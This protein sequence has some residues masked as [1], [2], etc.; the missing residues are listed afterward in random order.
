MKKAIALLLS[1][2]MICALAGCTKKGEDE[3]KKTKKT[4]ETEATEIETEESVTETEAT[5]EDTE[6]S[7]SESESSS[8]PETK[9]GT[10][11]KDFKL[12]S[13]FAIRNDQKNLDYEIVSS[14]RAYALPTSDG[15]VGKIEK[16]SSMIRFSQAEID[17]HEQLWNSL[18]AES[19]NL[20]IVLNEQYDK[21]RPQ[22]VSSIKDGTYSL[23]TSLYGNIWVYRADTDIFSY[24]MCQEIFSPSI[25][26][27]SLISHTY[28]ASD[29]GE[30][31][32]N[33]IVTDRAGFADFFEKFFSNSKLDEYDIGYA[34]DFAKVL[35]DENEKIEFVL[36]YDA[37]YIINTKLA[38]P[39]FFKIPAMYA[40][41]YLDVSLFGST[42]E[43]YALEA[44]AY[45]SIT[46][47][48]DGDGALDLISVDYDT[49]EYGL[50][51]NA[52]ISINGEVKGTIP[53]EAM[54]DSDNYFYYCFYLMKT[55]SG[56]YAYLST[57]FEGD[58]ETTFIFH[59]ENGQFVYVN[60][61][62][63]TFGYNYMYGIAPYYDPSRFSVTDTNDIM[64]TSSMRTTCSV[65]GN[66]GLPVKTSDFASKTG[67]AISKKE[68]TATKID[69]NG[70]PAGTITIPANTAIS[71]IGVDMEK[72]LGLFTTL[73]EDES[74]NTVFQMKVTLTDNYKIAYGDEQIPQDDLFLGIRYAD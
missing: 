52:K 74:K 15:R 55:D 48:I 49:D 31:F 46:W 65:I 11:L 9:P 16:E 27:S 64:A 14:N 25:D 13:D 23:D 50:M 20:N 69:E 28:R 39:H 24:V 1:I 59:Y 67:I 19:D 72:D 43:Y 21:L 47:D 2:S 8:E 41:D 44:D 36:S 5:S 68:I 54:G 34:K 3:T 56:F 30:Y 18:E 29:G 45:N 42:P 58:S 61:L 60:D 66:N 10:G 32:F 63:S 62:D 17:A 70:S 7:E 22:L 57:T 4:R 40:A 37:I 12:S 51:I 38:N 73:E 33:D 6:P 53:S 71:L 35:R 26:N